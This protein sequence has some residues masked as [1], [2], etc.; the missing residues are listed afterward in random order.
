M[1]HPLYLTIGLA[2]LVQPLQAEDLL[3]VTHYALE[4]DQ[5]LKISRIGVKI[6]D[7]QLLQAESLL[8]PSISSSASHDQNESS[9]YSGDNRSEVYS[10]SLTQRL[11]NR[12]SSKRIEQSETLSEESRLTLEE[13][14]QQLLL[15]TATTYFEQLSAENAVQ[16]AQ[17]EKHAVA[18]QLKQIRQQFEVGT[19]SMTDLQEVQARFDLVHAEGV[20][21]RAALENSRE[22][23]YEIVHREL[24]PLHPLGSN[25]LPITQTY[26]LQ[27]WI[28]LALENSL[29]LKQLQKQL[30]SARLTT[31][32]ER[33]AHYPTLNLVGSLSHSSNQ[34]RNYG[35]DIDSYSLG[36]EATLPLYTGGNTRA[37]VSEALLLQQQVEASLEQQQRS[38]VKTIR[39]NVLAVNT[40]LEMIKAQQ[41]V[42][43][44]AE[45]AFEATR[46]GV[47]VGTRTM[48]DL[49]D[50]QK[51]RY[52][53]QRDLTQARYDLLLARLALKQSAGLLTLEEI[54]QVNQLLSNAQSVNR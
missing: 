6:K 25:K 27:H 9:R 23:L 17:Q 16:L 31:E 32:I 52:S 30:E 42:L 4:Q 26:P 13:S 2:L 37:K 43:S 50:A 40:T 20:S 45:V 36:L 28:D 1:K 10:I 33:A 11:Y 54:E 5:Q 34:N 14:Y 51:E 41:Q 8:L 38:T 46:T 18:E 48:A 35:P 47:E 39:S 44:S 53:A 19:A 22:A 24:S 29:E 21:A 15:R 49:L 12:D 7:Q 3:Q